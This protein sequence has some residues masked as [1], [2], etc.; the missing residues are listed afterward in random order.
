[1]SWIN[2][3]ARQNSLCHV[4]TFFAN[5]LATTHCSAS[6]TKL[7]SRDTKEKKTFMNGTI[8]DKG[9]PCRTSAITYN[10]FRLVVQESSFKTFFYVQIII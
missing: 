3:N 5:F 8:M 6:K 4:L 9:E 2:S 10:V 7:T 1:M